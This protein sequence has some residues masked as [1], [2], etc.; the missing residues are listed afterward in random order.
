MTG[1]GLTVWWARPSLHPDPD[2]VLADLLDEHERARLDR[3]VPPRS[4]ARYRAA[5]ALT[6]VVLGAVLDRRP[7]ELRFDRT[8]DACGG[9]GHGKPRSLDADLPFSYTHSGDRVG[10]A[11]TLDGPVG[12]DTEEASR[13][14]HDRASVAR[15]MLSPDERLPDTDRELIEIWTRKE[16]LLKATGQ[17]LSARMRDI[18][19]H[20]PRVVAWYGGPRGPVSLGDLASDPGYVGAVAVLGTI[21]GTAVADGD[22]LLRATVARAA[23]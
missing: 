10:L 21:T 18:T 3:T 23:G 13:P 9:Y 16:A 15:R 20:G 14:L 7:A 5:H 4:R 8:C 12:V 17:G 2:G 19:L 11:V 22:E 6:R 1:V